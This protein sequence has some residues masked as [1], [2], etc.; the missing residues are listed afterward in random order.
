MGQQSSHTS[1]RRGGEHQPLLQG[2]AEEVVQEID[3]DHDGCVPRHGPNA[4]CPADPYS[5]LPVYTTIHRCVF[6]ETL[7]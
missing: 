6:E 2:D 5:D 4:V 1:S 3:H 7:P